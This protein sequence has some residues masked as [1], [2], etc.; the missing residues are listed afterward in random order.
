MVGEPVEL[1]HAPSRRHPARG[2]LRPQSWVWAAA[3][4]PVSKFGW[5]GRTL[6]FFLLHLPLTG[7]F[8]TCA[9][10]PADEDEEV[11]WAFDRVGEND[12]KNKST[13]CLLSKGLL[14]TRWGNI[15][16][17]RGGHPR[18]RPRACAPPR[19]GAAF[20]SLSASQRPGPVRS[21]PARGARPGSGPPAAPQ[22]RR[23]ACSRTGRPGGRRA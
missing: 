7:L 8:F 5:S 23:P 3:S 10:H 20:T 4:V 6:H 1:G 17:H 12:R 2:P 19:G 13:L 16:H 21:P 14:A 9:L 11:G 15:T 22:P 18:R